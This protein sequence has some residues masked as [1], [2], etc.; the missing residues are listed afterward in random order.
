LSHL[1]IVPQTELL[2]SHPLYLAYTSFGSGHFDATAK[3]VEV[4]ITSDIDPTPAM[5]PT[6]ENEKVKCRCGINYKKDNKNEREFCQGNRCPCR[7][8]NLMCQADCSCHKCQNGKVESM[9]KKFKRNVTF[10]KLHFKHASKL[11]HETAAASLIKKDISLL[12]KAWTLKESLLFHQIIMLHPILK[13]SPQKL[14][15]MYNRFC[16]KMLSVRRKTKMQIAKK[17]SSFEQ[18]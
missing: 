6:N 14:M 15:Q 9:Q 16:H 7:K 10:K 2:N 8:S 17:L 5:K 1:T 12:G 4:S 18:E 13:K 3:T 11:K